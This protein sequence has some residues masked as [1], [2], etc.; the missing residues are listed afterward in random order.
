MAEKLTAR[1]MQTVAQE[2]NERLYDRVINSILEQARVGLHSYSMETAD[3]LDDRQVWILSE[4][5]INA[6][7]KVNHQ[8]R[9][10][11]YSFGSGLGS[12]TSPRKLIITG[13]E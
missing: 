12:Y 7:Y 1:D 9:E 13:W 10:W 8:H 4:R 3:E 11:Y 2:A 5:L 6:D